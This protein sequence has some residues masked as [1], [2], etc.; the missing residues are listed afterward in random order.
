MN[1]PDGSPL[2]FKIC[3]KCLGRLNANFVAIGSSNTQLDGESF[4]SLVVGDF[5]AILLP[6]C[7][8]AFFDRRAVAVRT[9]F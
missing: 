7:F 4:I 8:V 9:L 2:D 6:A 5:A 3:C 1:R